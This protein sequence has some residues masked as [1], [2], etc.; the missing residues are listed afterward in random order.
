[1]NLEDLDNDLGYAYKILTITKQI[2]SF[3]SE[4]YKKITFKIFN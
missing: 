1:M 2:K 3:S 4:L